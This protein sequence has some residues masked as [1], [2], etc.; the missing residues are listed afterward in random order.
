M[1]SKGIGSKMI[2]QQLA[3]AKNRGYNIFSLDVNSKNIK[4]ERLYKRLGLKVIKEKKF[5]GKIPNPLY[6]KKMELFL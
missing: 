4:A 2:K 3:T 1:R 5:S 6:G